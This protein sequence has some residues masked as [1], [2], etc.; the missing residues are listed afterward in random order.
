MGIAVWEIIIWWVLIL[1]FVGLVMGIIRAV[2]E[3][4]AAQAVLT[5]LIPFYGLFYFFFGRT[6]K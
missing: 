5:I 3:R 1:V 6:K 2:K 4:S